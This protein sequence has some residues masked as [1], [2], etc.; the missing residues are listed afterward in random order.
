MKRRDGA[1][2]PHQRPRPLCLELCQ[3]KGEGKPE[4]HTQAFPVL[5]QKEEIWVEGGTSSTHHHAR[6]NMLRVLFKVKAT[7]ASPKLSAVRKQKLIHPFLQIQEFPK[8]I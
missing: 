4:N 6:T 7:E 8:R 3:G 5:L 1:W 2:P